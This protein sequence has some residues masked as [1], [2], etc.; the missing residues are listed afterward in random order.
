MRGVGPTQGSNAMERAVY[1]DKVRGVIFG[2]AIGDALGLGT[3]FLSKQEV[4]IYYPNRLED[5]GQIKRD[6]H[7]SR[8]AAGDWTDDTD[9]MLCIL[10][11]LLTQGRIDILDVAFRIHRWACEGGMG[12][13]KTVANVVYSQDFRQQPHEASER[14]WLSS[15]KQAAANGGVMRTSVLGVWESES[16]DAVRRNAE[17]VCRI[18]HYDPRCVAS[19][20]IICL[21]IRSLLREGIHAD[22]LVDDLTVTADEYDARVREYIEKA[23]QSEIAKLALDEPNSIGYTLKAMAT[24]IWALIHPITY[25]DG[26]LSVIH[27]GGDADTN[28]SVAGA[29]LGARFGFSGIPRKWVDSLLHR[30]DLEVRVDRLLTMI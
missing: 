17:T 2:H 26:I 21:A 11:S 8:W 10:D 29:I 22:R 27:E 30:A 13:G 7:R 16:A 18:T 6:A 20:V 1:E 12:I 28:A 19:C 3:E 15:G 14:V 25:R 9:Q 23:S 4:R 24:G 5:L